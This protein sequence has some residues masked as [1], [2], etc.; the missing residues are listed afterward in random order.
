MIHRQKKNSWEC[1]L[2]SVAMAIDKDPD[3]LIKELGH[4]G[5]NIIG[6]QHRQGF[7]VQEFIPIFLKLGLTATQFQLRPTSSYSDRTVDLGSPA[8]DNMF[9]AIVHTLKGVL[10]CRTR[11]GRGHAL[12]FDS[13]D[14]H[15][16]DNIAKTRFL[17]VDDL[18]KKGLFAT[19]AY[20]IK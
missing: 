7:H 5:S 4:D 2:Y 16:P 3:W 10:I 11:S 19:E 12:A 8:R 15:D 9:N 20:V 1:L 6:C 13:G 17:G 18:T 14:L